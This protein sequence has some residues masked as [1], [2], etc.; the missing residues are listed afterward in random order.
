MRAFMGIDTSKNWDDQEED[1]DEAATLINLD[2]TKSWECVPLA[3]AALETAALTAALAA[4]VSAAAPPAAA[5]ARATQATATALAVPRA[6]RLTASVSR[7]QL[8]ADHARSSR[9][10]QDQVV[11]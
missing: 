3:P 9:H 4:A 6:V 7:P 11:G 5:T 1:E 10:R 2:K 8:A